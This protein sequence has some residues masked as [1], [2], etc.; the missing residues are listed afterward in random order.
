MGR[1]GTFPGISLCNL[2]RLA[3]YYYKWRLN[4]QAL[5]GARAVHRL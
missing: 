4:S 3:L 5:P 2:S 1:S